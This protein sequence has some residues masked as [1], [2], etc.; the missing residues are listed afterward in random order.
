MKLSN[1][2]KYLHTYSC[3]CNILLSEL[4]ALSN[5]YMI[6][7]YKVLFYQEC[8]F[9]S[10]IKGIDYCLCENDQE[11]VLKLL[12]LIQILTNLGTEKS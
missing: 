1:N 5:Q 12:K 3:L 9:G 6:I 4:I 11:K 8:L 7:V 10:P 2:K